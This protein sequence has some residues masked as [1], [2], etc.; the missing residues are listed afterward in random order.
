MIQSDLLDCYFRSEATNLMFFDCLSS[1]P[2]PTSPV[3]AEFKLHVRTVKQNSDF[4]SSDCSVAGGG[5]MKSMKAVVFGLLLTSATV[6]L[7]QTTRAT[8][9][10]KAAESEKPV[11]I[12]VLHPTFPM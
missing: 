9:V 4:R 8:F 7:A 5:A 3:A 1:E 11:V 12:Q 2:S 6:G 10:V